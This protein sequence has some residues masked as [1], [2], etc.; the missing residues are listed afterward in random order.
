MK[1]MNEKEQ[2]SNKL[3]I[4]SQLTQQQPQQQAHVLGVKLFAFLQRLKEEYPFIKE[5]HFVEVKTC[6]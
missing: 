2:N 1:T 3:F 5:V 4:L 6:L